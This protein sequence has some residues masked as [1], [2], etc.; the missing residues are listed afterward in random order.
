MM[1]LY[2]FPISHYSEKARWALDYKSVDYDPVHL[3]PGPHVLTIKRLAKHTTVPVLSDGDVHVQGSSEIIDYVEQ[4]FPKKPLTPTDHDEARRAREL[5]DLAD[6]EIGGPLRRILYDSLIRDGDTVKHLWTQHGP[7][8]GKLFY[9]VAYPAL[10]RAVRR[11]YALK[12]DTRRRFLD[13]IEKFDAA[14]EGREFLAADAF[15]RADLTLAALL[16]PLI[17]PPEHPLTWPDRVPPEPVELADRI[18]DS[19]TWRH[20]ERMYRDH[21]GRTRGFGSD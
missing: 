20:A 14:L 11:R 15:G 2:T 1:R 16:A 9:A 13:A 4:R 7:A 18:R 19:A 3:L 10:A 6:H 17:T 5:C 12:P 21:R 8:W